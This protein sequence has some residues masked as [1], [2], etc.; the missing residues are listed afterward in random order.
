MVVES[1]I[2]KKRRD[3]V[4]PHAPKQCWDEIAPE[5]GV[6]K[7]GVS[8]RPKRSWSASIAFRGRLHQISNPVGALRSKKPVVPVVALRVRGRNGV[9]EKEHLA[10]M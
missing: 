5:H 9:G 1:K 2:R 3:G 10:L 6:I 7:A 4:E 8:G